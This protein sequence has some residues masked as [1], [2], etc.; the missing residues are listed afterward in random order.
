MTKAAGVLGIVLPKMN[1]ADASKCKAM[2]GAIRSAIDSAIWHNANSLHWV[3][4]SKQGWLKKDR[5]GSLTNA[6]AKFERLNP[7]VLTGGVRLK[8]ALIECAWLA[9]C[10][11]ETQGMDNAHFSEDSTVPAD[12]RGNPN[13]EAKPGQRIARKMP[14]SSLGAEDQYLA[15][16]LADR[17]HSERPQIAQPETLETAN[18]TQCRELAQVQQIGE[19]MPEWFGGFTLEPITGGMGS[20]L[21]FEPAAAECVDVEPPKVDRC[22]ERFDMSQRSR[23]ADGARIWPVNS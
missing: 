11:L 5:L 18:R 1:R 21:P 2:I 16:M 23:M 4:T 15:L 12:D 22:P 7:A 19:A 17:I 9:Y 20:G 3:Y 8:A 6:I 10:K 14:D 13:M